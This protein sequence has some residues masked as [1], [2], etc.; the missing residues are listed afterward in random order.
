MT[1]TQSEGH[2]P[3]TTPAIYHGLQAQKD[4]V[5]RR[6]GRNT[7]QAL[8]SVVEKISKSFEQDEVTIGV[9][10]YFQKAFDTIKYRIL[11]SKVLTYRICDT[12]HRWFTNY[13]S[14]LPNNCKPKHKNPA[15]VSFKIVMQQLIR[16]HGDNGGV[17]VLVILVC[18]TGSLKYDDSLFDERGTLSS[19]LAVV[20]EEINMSKLREICKELDAV[21]LKFF[22][23]MDELYFERMHLEQHLKGGHLLMAKAR[24][25]MGA[26]TVGKLQYNEDDLNEALYHVNISDEARLS[27][28]AEVVQPKTDSSVRQRTKKPGD[29]ESTPSEE[30]FEIVHAVSEECKPV[31][32]D[33]LKWFGVLV[34]Q[35]LRQCQQNF[36]KAL[37][38]TCTIANLQQD[39]V[40]LKDKYCSL[41][42]E[43]ENL[44]AAD[45]TQ[46]DRIGAAL[47]NES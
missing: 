22:S 13:L 10:L 35:P 33:P 17:G 25:S 26:K 38:T 42:K 20:S 30:G 23:A 1:A 7:T 8:V 5:S 3:P 29:L 18:E 24:Y 4:A 2:L 27:L 41:L 11:L 15:N 44:M 37:E 34:P 19:C 47:E 43:K 21:L 31:R 46:D 9:L 16:V 12:H 40:D 32:K 45:A 28:E 6:G 14:R 39:L 36:K